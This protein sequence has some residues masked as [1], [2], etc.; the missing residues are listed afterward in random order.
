MSRYE[1][2]SIT[3][4]RYDD[5][6]WREYY[7]LVV[8]MR[9]N[10]H[11]LS[12]SSS[13]EELKSKTTSR[14]ESLPGFEHQLLLENNK[15]IGFLDCYVSSMGTENQ[16][17]SAELDC[18][19]SV[20]SEL[21]KL[22]ADS[23][24]NW[25]VGHKGKLVLICSCDKHIIKLLEQLGAKR[26]GGM[27]QYILYRDRANDK[28]IGQWLQNI[29][30]Q[31]KDL[32]F[33]FYDSLPEEYI[34]SMAELFSQGAKDMPEENES[35]LPTSVKPEELRKWDRLRKKSNLLGYRYLV[36]NERDKVVGLSVVQINPSWPEFILQYMTTVDRDYRGRGLAKWMKAAMHVKVGQDFPENN[37]AVTYMR[38]INEPMMAINKAMGF[39]LTREGGEFELSVPIQDKIDS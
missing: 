13:W 38:A 29:P 32:R 6:L 1:L 3:D 15:P 31:N 25:A 16:F 39:E 10:Q 26:M 5:K 21:R 27:T 9:E 12:T 22:L 24:R 35:E 30:V 17:L 33:L 36:V 18:C 8:H 2:M 37:R 23:L 19:Q 11:L 28:N 34:D 4:E 14:C 20:D 7:K